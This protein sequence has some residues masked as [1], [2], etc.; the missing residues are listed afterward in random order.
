MIKR[1]EAGRA[2]GSVYAPTSKSIAHRLLICAAMCQG[3]SRIEGITESADALATIDCLKKFGVKIEYANGTAIV[4]GIDFTKAE[5]SGILNCN[6]SGSTLRFLIPL[7]MLSGKEVKFTGSE[8]LL[9]RSQIVYERIAKEYG[10]YFNNDGKE[11]TVKGPL[12]AGEYFIDG[13]VSS[14]F[15]TGMLLALS[16]LNGDS[17]IIVN[18][19]IESRPYVD[20]T[21]ACMRDFGVKVY[22]DTNWSFLIFGAQ[23]Y[24]AKHI[25][26]EGDWS[27]AAFIDAFNILGGDV[28]LLGLN[29]NS[30]QGDKV[31]RRLYPMLDNGFCEIDITDCPDLGPILFTLA[32]I[33][34]GAKFVGTKR[35][36]DKESDR[37]GVMVE[38][39]SK[40]GAEI[41]CDEN[42]VIVKSVNLHSPTKRLYGHNDHRVVMSL[43]VLCTIL[44]GE[45]E[46]C[47]AISK[48]Y[49]D[50]FKNINELGIKT[51]DIE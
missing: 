27:G 7:A 21:I 28:K 42:S 19:K 23:E 40:F 33:K 31:Y 14:Q 45:I 18:R 20:M 35:L 6:E 38:E 5:V 4:N 43:A 49:P 9:K 22:L 25:T 44:G 46:G 41:V 32:A 10:F 3:E 34:H 2:E 29:E 37:V 39:L 16:T 26:V 1:I 47:E 48:S 8:R 24:K 11:I 15:I 12:F 13:D 51:Y 36:R 30:A 17:K 50:F